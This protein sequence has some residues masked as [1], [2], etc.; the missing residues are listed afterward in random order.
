MRAAIVLLAASV[1]LSPAFALDLAEIKVRGSLNVLVAADEVPETFSWTPGSEPGM[2]REMIEGF[3]RLH[4]LEM[5][6]VPVKDWDDII[7]ALRRGDGDVILGINDTEARRKQVDFTREVMPSRH[8]VLTRKPDAPIHELLALRAVKVGVPFGTTWAE[9]AASAGVPSRHLVDLPDMKA[10]LAALRARKI[11][12]SV[13][14]LADVTLALRGDPDLQAGM[15]VGPP[16]RAA[17]AVRKT[18]PGLKRAF[19]EHIEASRRTGSWSRLVVKYY[20][21]AA[22]RVLDRAKGQ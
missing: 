8:V 20:G 16:G 4:K 17:W 13:V 1:L 11:T 15:F 3:A 12:A 19:D 18:D 2:E 9:A 5:R 10:I 22:L 7:P 14:P 6:P 21:E